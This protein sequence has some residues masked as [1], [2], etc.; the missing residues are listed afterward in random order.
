M[1]AFLQILGQLK[2]NNQQVVVALSGSER[3]VTISDITD[4]A[5]TLQEVNTNNRFDLHY[6][7]V[8]VV[9]TVAS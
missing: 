7:Q 1:S 2:A 9:G 8:V 6:T 4:D 5:V 3:L